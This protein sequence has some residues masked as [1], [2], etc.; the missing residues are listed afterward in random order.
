MVS[1]LPIV[2]TATDGPSV[3]EP[4]GALETTSVPVLPGSRTLLSVVVP[5]VLDVSAL[6]SHVAARE[7]ESATP[8]EPFGFEGELVGHDP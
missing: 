7:V 4:L 5:V 8:L 6:E 2:P 1:A 3:I